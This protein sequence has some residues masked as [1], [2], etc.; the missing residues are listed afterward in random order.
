MFLEPSCHVIQVAEASR[1]PIIRKDRLAKKNLTE[2]R[3][4][5]KE[6]REEERREGEEEDGRREEQQTNHQFGE[7][8]RNW[9]QQW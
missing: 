9:L 7:R 5:G 2:E 8:R 6:M 1:W 4:E 3:K